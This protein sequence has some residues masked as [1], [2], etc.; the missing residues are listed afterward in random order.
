VQQ[1]T[2]GEFLTIAA[3]QVNWKDL[4][5]KTE[6]DTMV[7]ASADILAEHVAG[8]GIY[9]TGETV[10][11]DLVDDFFD[12]VNMDQLLMEQARD[13][14]LYGIHLWQKYGDP[15]RRTLTDLKIV[16]LES[17]LRVKRKTNGD[18]DTLYQ[19]TE[20]GGGAVPAS[21]LVIHKW[22]PSNQSAFGR[23][24]AQGMYMSKTYKLVIRDSQGVVLSSRTIIVPSL[25]DS[26]TMMY[27]MMVKVFQRYGMPY[28]VYVLGD[29]TSGVEAAK[30]SSADIDA[31]T[32]SIRERREVAIDKPFQIVSDTIDP[33][34]RFE[35]Y[36]TEMSNQNIMAMQ[37]PM[38]KLFAAPEGLTEASARTALRAFDRQIV[39]RQRFQR[40]IV[41]RE[42]VV[43]LLE[44]NAIKPADADIDVL[45]GPVDKPEL[46][47]EHLASYF[48][49][50]AIKVAELR[51]NLRKMGI[52]LDKD[53]NMPQI[54]EAPISGRQRQGEKPAAQ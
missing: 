44:G 45:H 6:A 13:T 47:H 33:R 23:G 36:F 37:S 9:T 2:Q 11:K 52:D 28:Q 26:R 4:I 20:Y 15:F 41:E 29:A 27:D 38:L 22:R 53:D 7:M 24:I 40:R 12:D 51:R 19:T 54:S 46:R 10:A 16:P 32:A 48:Q 30:A 39:A 1:Y 34:S 25:Y 43:P 8:T 31:M 35:A 50:N 42:V 18:W 21:Q 3:E 49:G 14:H 5:K 17:I